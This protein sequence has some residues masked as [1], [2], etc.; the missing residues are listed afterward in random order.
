MVSSLEGKS[1]MSREELHL[2]LRLT[3]YS[4]VS[5]ATI[6]KSNFH[7]FLL[8]TQAPFHAWVVMRPMRD[9]RTWLPVSG[10][11]GDDKDISYQSD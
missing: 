6:Y 5:N 1:Q 10:D 7:G 8:Y 11:T 9:E 4:S 3:D 2:P